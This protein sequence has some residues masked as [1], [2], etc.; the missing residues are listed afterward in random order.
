MLCQCCAT[1]ACGP[2]PANTKYWPNAGLMLVH[3]LRRWPNI[4]PP[5]GECPVFGGV[6][7]ATPVDTEHLYN[8]YTTSAIRL[9]RWSN[10]V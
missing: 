8:I 3:R 6:L 7:P 4:K 9:R 2:V 1:V 10:I 5:L